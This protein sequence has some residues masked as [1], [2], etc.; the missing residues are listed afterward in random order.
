MT[1]CCF[2]YATIAARR[3]LFAPPAPLAPPAAA[4][5]VAVV[6][7]A[8]ALPL[9]LL[10]LPQALSSPPRAITASANRA[11]RGLLA[12]SFTLLFLSLNRDCSAATEQ[13]VDG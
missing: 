4:D 11:P 8:P 1:P 10:A 12:M 5:A 13:R 3:L 6:L 2:R 9:E 7:V